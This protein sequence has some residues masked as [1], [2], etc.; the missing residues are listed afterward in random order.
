MIDCPSSSIKRPQK[1]RYTSLKYVD[2]K[3]RRNHR[4]ALRGTLKALVWALLCF[5][6]FFLSYYFHAPLLSF[7]WF[8]I[9]AHVPRVSSCYQARLLQRRL[10]FFCPSQA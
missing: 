6:I 9:R 4:R 2:P 1:K 5:I 10:H 8:Y 3:F 7:I